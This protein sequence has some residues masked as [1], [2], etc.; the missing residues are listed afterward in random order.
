MNNVLL[1]QK[2]STS[3]DQRITAY[4][5]ELYRHLNLTPIPLKPKSKVPLVRWTDGNWNP[6]LAE[7][8]AWA[9]K[10][11]INW[12]VRCGENLA[13]LDFDSEE[14]FF[15]F[16]C[17]HQ[18]P[19]QCPVVKTGRGYHVWLKP[20]HPLR[21][22]TINGIELKCVGSFVVAPPSLHQS[23]VQYE[24]LLPPSVGIPEVD[25]NQ[26]FGLQDGFL[27]LL[28]LPKR[29]ISTPIK[30]PVMEP[31]SAVSATGDEKDEFQRLLSLVSVYPGGN[32][33][34]CPWH[35]DRQGMPS[36]APLPSLSV[37]WAKCQFYCHSPRCGEHGGLARLRSLVYGQSDCQN[38]PMSEKHAKNNSDSPIPDDPP[39]DSWHTPRLPTKRCGVAVHLRHRKQ[40]RRQRIIGVLCGS[41][42]CAVCG[43]HLKKKWLHQ[44]TPLIMDSEAV[45]LSIITKEEWGKVYRRIR[46]GGGEFAKVELQ[47][48]P[49]TIFTTAKGGL[50]LPQSLRMSV[51]GAAIEA[52][53][54]RH[55]AISTS[56]G[57]QLEKKEEGEPEWERI[58]QLPITVEDARDVVSQL[59]LKPK[60][61]S[62]WGAYKM[63]VVEGFEVMLPESWF[64]DSERGYKIFLQWLVH[65][66][67]KERDGPSLG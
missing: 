29:Y 9:C 55:R 5:L 2:V 24:F 59:G 35:P 6:T 27:E 56:R 8:Q 1:Q 32:P 57:W 58:G 34:W 11:N 12:G 39:W 33:T 65:G 15:S 38:N 17:T 20:R 16:T 28:G 31:K 51:L 62:S 41:W 42:D 46:R 7:L 54:F 60:E 45:Y 47:D 23:G 64:D 30:G 18:L 63:G 22:Q 43:P 49:I 10:P 52:A 50:L 61:I 40:P 3:Q 4:Y 66:P 37:D 21:S 36:R 25:L 19:P 53:T 48:G 13:A 26:V 14:A 67:A 44:F